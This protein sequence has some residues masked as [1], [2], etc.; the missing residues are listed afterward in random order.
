MVNYHLSIDERTVIAQLNK[1]SIS[2]NEIAHHL[3]FSLSAISRELR[4]NSFK[5]G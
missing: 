3:G 4:R 1:S 5:T 2:I